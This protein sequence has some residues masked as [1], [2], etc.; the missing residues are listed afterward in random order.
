MDILIVGKSGSGKSKLGDLIRN[1]IFK[2]DLNSTITTDDPDRLVKTMGSGTNKYNL[3][4]IQLTDDNYLDLP[5]ADVVIEIKTTKL[6]EALG[7][8]VRK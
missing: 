2:A 6:V 3:K 8:P 5:E 7:K 4:V 1:A